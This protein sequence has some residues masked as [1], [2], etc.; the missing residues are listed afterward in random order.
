MSSRK[1]AIILEELGLTYES[2]Y[3]VF[4]NDDMKSPEYTKYNPN[5][6]IPTIIDHWNNDFVL[7]YAL[8]LPLAE[9][10]KAC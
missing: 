2:I 7:W 5:G 8:E 4:E 1:V 9:V 6:R 10:A 3:L